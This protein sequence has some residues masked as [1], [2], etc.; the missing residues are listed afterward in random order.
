MNR[1]YV[2]ADAKALAVAMVQSDFVAP[3]PRKDL[4]VMGR[5]GQALIETA[6]YNMQEG[7]FISEHD[8]KIG[9][10]LA[11]ILSGGDLAGP[12]PVSESYILEL[13]VEAFLRLCGEPKTQERIVALLETGKPLRN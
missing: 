13:E 6:L 1:D 8:R 4:P 12:T 11:G 3:V 9:K 5:G 10:E 7:H 2:V